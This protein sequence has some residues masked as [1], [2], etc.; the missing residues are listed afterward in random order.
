MQRISSDIQVSNDEIALFVTN[1]H[2]TAKSAYDE[3]WLKM[4][5]IYMNSKR[6]ILSVLFSLFKNSVYKTFILCCPKL[7]LK[8]SWYL[9]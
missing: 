3:N 5:T 8:D 9:E 2:R 6:F 4:T 7:F 1:T